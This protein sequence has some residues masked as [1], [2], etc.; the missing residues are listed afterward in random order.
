VTS[1]ANSNHKR[2]LPLTIPI[3]H[4]PPPGKPRWAFRLDVCG[5]MNNRHQYL[6]ESNLGLH[7]PECTRS[8]AIVRTYRGF[9]QEW[10]RVWVKT[11]RMKKRKRR[12]STGVMKD[13]FWP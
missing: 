1:A 13:L 11:A 4:I 9:L 8:S 5:E 10:T 3:P 2:V 7:P 6:L 12:F